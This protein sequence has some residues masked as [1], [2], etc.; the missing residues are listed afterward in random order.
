[1][2]G[3]EVGKGE[4]DAAKQMLYPKCLPNTAHETKWATDERA[5]ETEA[6]G[7]SGVRQER[8]GSLLEACLQQGPQAVH[9]P[10]LRPLQ[11]YQGK[12]K[13]H[14]VVLHQQETHNRNLRRGRASS[15]R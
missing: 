12:D 11:G 6:Q 14:P 5:P 2:R 8:V 3:S 9:L 15:G 10:I 13:N 7:V 4:G 1:M